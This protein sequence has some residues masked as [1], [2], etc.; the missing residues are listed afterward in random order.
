M[1]VYAIDHPMFS[2][3]LVIESEVER[4]D[5]ALAAWASMYVLRN[6]D[7]MLPIDSFT[8]TVQHP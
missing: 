1:I 6:F 2:E 5:R 4:T 7:E 8:V 3:P